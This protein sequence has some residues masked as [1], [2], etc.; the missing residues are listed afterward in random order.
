MRRDFDEA[1]NPQGKYRI[2]A[3]LTPSTPPA[4]R[5]GDAVASDSLL[6]Q[7]ADQF[8]TPMNFAG[9]PGISFPAIKLKWIAYRLQITGYD[10][11]ESKY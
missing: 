10:Y 3:I 6:I 7:F 2:D 4:F 8:T 1:F 5:F 9:T 11:C